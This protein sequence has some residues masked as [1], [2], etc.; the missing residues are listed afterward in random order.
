MPTP[1]IPLVIWGIGGLL[2]GGA[3]HELTP[4]KEQR[5]HDLENLGGAIFGSNATQMEQADEGAE[6]D[7][8]PGTVIDACSTCEP[9]DDE[10]EQAAKD[11][12]RMSKKELES[13]AKKNGYEDAHALKRD[14]GLDSRS[15]IFVDK[16]GNMY[17]GPRQGTGTPQRLGININGL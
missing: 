17:A 6:D 12:K 9:P 3:A 4:G 7:S 13:A 5:E 15:D 14:Y 1:A 16:Q 2:L 10:D 11:S 8:L